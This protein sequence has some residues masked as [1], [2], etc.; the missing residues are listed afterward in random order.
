MAT[1]KD[2][3]GQRFGRLIAL[4]RINTRVHHT[5]WLCRCG[6]GKSARVAYQRLVAGKTRSCGCLRRDLN[7]ARGTRHG[8]T[9]TS[10]YRSWASMLT[11]CR[12]PNR[13]THQRYMGRGIKVCQRWYSFENFLADMSERPPGTSLDRINP[14]GDYEPGNCRWATQREQMANM[15]RNVKITFGRET[16]ILSEWCRLFRINICTVKGR[17]KKGWDWHRAL[18]IPPGIDVLGERVAEETEL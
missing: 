8:L 11:R 14:D 4:E 16:K 12:N 17:V 15:S 10:T 18:A 13:N 6:C 7:L 2:L 1:F 9:G 3:T 5:L